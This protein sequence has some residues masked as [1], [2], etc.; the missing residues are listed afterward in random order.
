MCT[1]KEL[2]FKYDGVKNSY[3][4]KIKGEYI[5]FGKLEL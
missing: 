4:G 2:I 3:G 1:L 5:N